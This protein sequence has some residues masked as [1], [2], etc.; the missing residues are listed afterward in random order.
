[1]KS[2]AD[3]VGFTENTIKPDFSR[4]N[5]TDILL[6]ETPFL[7]STG[8]EEV[9]AYV[10]SKYNLALLSL[11]SYIKHHSDLSVRLVNMVKDRM[12]EDT[13]LEN[14]RRNPPRVLGVSLYSYSLSFA[15]KIL[16]RVR[17]ELPGIHICVGGPHVSIFP[18]ETANLEPVDSIVL[19]DGEKPFLE[20]CRQVI[21][22]GQLDLTSLPLGAYTRNNLPENGEIPSAVYE[23]LDNLP[24]PDVTL[25]GDH[26]RYRDFLSNRVMAIIASSRGCPYVCNYCSS[27]LSKYRSFS[28]EYVIRMMRHYKEKGVEYIEFWDDTFNPSDRR[29]REFADALLEADLGLSWGIHGAV[30]NHVSYDIMVKFKRAGLKVIQFG[31]ES[32]NPRI[33]NYLNK[34]LDWDKVKHAVDTCSRAGV[35]TVNNMIINI[36]GQ[37]RKE[38]LE[39]FR[40]L[41][42][43]NPTFL[44]I[45]I[46]NWAPGTTHYFKALEE[47]VVPYDYWR[48]HAT[49]PK[50][51][52]PIV[53]PINDTDLDEVYQMR[54]RFVRSYYFNPSYIFNFLKTMEASDI[55]GAV[56]IAW[57]M[58]KSNV[59]L[60][61]GT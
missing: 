53:Q 37:T 19:G 30:V 15:H 56:H 16:C 61:F 2:F 51:T 6:L 1:M 8:G 20:I 23:N 43:I 29:A 41:K 12:D 14:I 22:N 34:R 4:T 40:L 35:H 33:L 46:Y 26:K 24:M 57:L 7:S 3:K 45:N 32:F 10:K 44:N 48:E 59:K 13:L 27:G 36:Q 52:D 38:I 55:L 9:K 54:E 31:V 60:S 28:V 58:G 11:G 49:Q 17:K 50:E 21:K 25:L 5:Y 18:K 47:S 42:K 39:D